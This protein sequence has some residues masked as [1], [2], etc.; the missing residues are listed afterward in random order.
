MIQ[1]G[2]RGVL[3][4]WGKAVKEL[5]PGFHW[6]I[7][8]VHGVKTTPVRS[9]T[10]HLP[11]QKVMTVDGL[12]YDVSVSVVYRVDDATRALTRVDHLDA[13][14]R[15]AISIVVAEVLRVRDQAQLVERVSLDRELS[16]RIERLDRPLGTGRRAGRIH[17]DRPGQGRAPDDPAPRPDDGA[18]PGV[19]RPDRRGPR[20][21]IRPGDDR[22]RAPA[23]REVEPTL[24]S[25]DTTTRPG[26]PRAGRCRRPRC[27]PSRRSREMRRHQPTRP[28]PRR[29]PQRPRARRL[30]GDAGGDCPSAFAVVQPET[31]PLPLPEKLFFCW[32]T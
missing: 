10:I 30:R 16:E 19:A 26:D 31:F 12:V 7:P 11:G 17:D 27:R 1:S 22:D 5:E 28:R 23:G 4:R 13:G 3:F 2:R 15:A 18:R 8:L 32:V 24:P 29:P 9:V 14:C 6:L 21:R 20:R 25:P